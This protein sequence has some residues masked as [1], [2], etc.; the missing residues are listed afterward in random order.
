MSTVWMA[1]V[2]SKGAYDRNGNFLHTLWE[3]YST[4]YA[5]PGST[6]FSDTQPARANFVGWAGAIGIGS[7]IEDIMGITIKGNEN[8]I[9]WKIRLT[10]AFG[11]DHLYFNGPNGENFVDLACAERVSASSGAKLTVKAEHAFKLR[12]SVGGHSEMIQVEAGEHQYLVDGTDGRE[13]YLGIKTTK[14]PEKYFTADQMKKADSAV[15]F[16]AEGNSSRQDGPVITLSAG[17]GLKTS[18]DRIVIPAT[19]EKADADAS[20]SMLWKCTTD[21]THGWHHADVPAIAAEENNTEPTWTK[22]GE[23]VELSRGQ[24]RMFIRTGRGLIYYADAGRGLDSG[25]TEPAS[26]VENVGA[27]SDM[28]TFKA[29][30]ATGTSV[31]PDAKVAAIEYTKPVDAK[32]RIIMTAQPTGSGHTNGRLTV[33][34]KD[35]AADLANPTITRLFDT[36]LYN[37]NF[38]AASMDE[39]YYGSNIALLWENGRGDVLAYAMYSSKAIIR[40]ISWVRITMW[41]AL[42]WT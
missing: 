18:A 30:V 2:C 28:F 32:E 11:I 42:K 22:G 5:M 25:E 38:A 7:L 26:D 35:N 15:S 14:A 10:E 27:G 17:K 8:V 40:W 20:A 34:G 36:S 33:F 13:S 12:V 19:I 4:E 16:G 29:P 37:G 6:E 24:L 39:M 41:Q 23:I 3:N 1:D 21:E 9:E 31:T